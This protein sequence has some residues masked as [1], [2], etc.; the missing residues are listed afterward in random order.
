MPVSKEWEFAA[1]AG[2]SKQNYPWGDMYK[3]KQMNVWEGNF[4]KENLLLDGF[5]GLAPAKSFK[6]NDYGVY[7]MLGKLYACIISHHQLLFVTIDYQRD[8][9]LAPCVIV[10]FMH[11]HHPNH[12][13]SNHIFT[14][15]SFI[16][17][18]V[19]LFM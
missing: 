1:R 4:P 3:P 6:P 16:C 7:N 8:H 5:Y 19:C 11:N 12:S 18:F 14:L 13:H 9:S 2:R 17:L 15:L 10:L